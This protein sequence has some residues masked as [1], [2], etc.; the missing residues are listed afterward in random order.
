MR[1]E[2]NY[3]I[4]RQFR[5]ISWILTSKYSFV[6]NLRGCHDDLFLTFS[7]RRLTRQTAPMDYQIRGSE[8]KSA[9]RLLDRL[10]AAIRTKHYSPKTEE[11]YVR[12]TRK[13]V[14]FHQKR[15]PIEMGETE[16][17]Q[18]LQQLAVNKSVAASTQNQALNALLFLYGSVLYKPLG[19]LPNVLRAKRPKR[20]PT[21][22][23]QEEVRQLFAAMKGTYSLMARPL[24]GAGLRLTECTNLRVKDVD[25]SAN[26]IL[27]RD[28]KGFI[29][30]NSGYSQRYSNIP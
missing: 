21:V 1:L 26:Q 11:A 27:V 5:R 18:F 9:P 14:L 20:L 7:R 8:T 29:R 23:R 30:A 12:W 22:L 3:W 19:K 25:F 6:S 28:G 15:H 4:G 17:A 10:R 2:P 13:F 16:I 24:Y